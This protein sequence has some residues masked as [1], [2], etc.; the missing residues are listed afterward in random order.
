MPSERIPLRLS[1]EAK[2]LDSIRFRWRTSSTKISKGISCSSQ[3]LHTDLTTGSPGETT[4]FRHS[5]CCPNTP[6][7][8][9]LSGGRQL[10]SIVK[11]H[12]EGRE[13]EQSR[14]YVAA[15][16]YARLPES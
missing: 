12:S 8:R 1:P 16:A 3:H 10:N 5:R 15:F 13:Y 14:L 4:D 11:P 9:M 7:R 2:R 6:Q